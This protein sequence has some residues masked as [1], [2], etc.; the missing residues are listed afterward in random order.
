[1]NRR[2]TVALLGKNAEKP[3]L[4]DVSANTRSEIHHALHKF[5]GSNWIGWFQLDEELSLGID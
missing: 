3:E 2:L 1:M 4:D 5:I